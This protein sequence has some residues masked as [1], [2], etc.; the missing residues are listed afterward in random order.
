MPRLYCRP[1]VRDDVPAVV[2][3]LADDPLGSGRE[4]ATDT[5]PDA[6]WRAF[7][8]MTVQRGNELLVA[9]DDGAVVACLQLT[10]IPG[11]SRLGAFRAQIE[12]VRVH[13]D[14]R[15]RGIGELLMTYAIGRARDAGCQLVQ[16]TTDRSRPDALRFYERLGFVASHVGMKMPLF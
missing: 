10:I 4:Q 8:A 11:I 5:L 13:S 15:G 3:L 16:L 6:Y 1:A 2:R 12:G 9:D 14:Y 7:D